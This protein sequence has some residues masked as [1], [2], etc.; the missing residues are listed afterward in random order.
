MHRFVSDYVQRDCEVEDSS[1]VSCAHLK[2]SLTTLWKI[3]PPP[4]FA[5][6][7]E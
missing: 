6:L 2:N 5:I 4:Y 7:R 3:P 1:E